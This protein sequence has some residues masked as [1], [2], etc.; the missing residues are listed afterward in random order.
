MEELF[1][2]SLISKTGPVP[3]SMLQSC[4]YVLVYFS[5]SWCKPCQAFT[6]VLDMLYDSVNS[7]DKEIEVIY[8]SRDNT[9]EEFEE[10]YRKMPWLS[11]DFADSDRRSM[12]KDRF[13]AK[14]VPS[15]FLLNSSGEVKKSDCVG[16]VRNKGP[17]CLADWNTALVS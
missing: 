2:A 10:Y 1:G 7:F 9:L 17:L 3:T 11:L 8:I 12:L 15:L 6:P 13:G 4:K 5:A 14:S 16:D